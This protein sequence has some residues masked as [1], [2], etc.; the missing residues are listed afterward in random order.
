MGAQQSADA[1]AAV[2]EVE[3]EIAAEP[4]GC[5]IKLYKYVAAGSAGAWELVTNS[6]R[7]QFYDAKEDTSKKSD[8]YLEVDGS[9]VDVRV[10]QAAGFIMDPPH[11]RVTFNA[12]GSVWAM[13]VNDTML[14]K[15]FAVDLNNK[16]FQNTYGFENTEAGRTKGLGADYA[17]RMFSMEG[18]ETRVDEPMDV[19]G[20]VDQYETPDKLNERSHFEEDDDDPILGV[21]MGATDNSYLM[22]AGGRFDVLRNVV[23]GGVEDKA[24]SFMLTPG[25]HKGASTSSFTP[26]RVL[27]AQCERRMNL[28]T[29]HD[30]NLLHHADVE[31][32]KIVSTYNFQKDSVDIPIKEIAHDNKAAQ[33]DGTSTFLGLDANRLCRWDLRTAGGKVTDSSVVSYQ[34]GKDYSRGTNFN[35]MATSGDGFVVVGAQDGTIRLYSSS[36]LTR[37]KTSIPGMGAPVTSVDVTYDGKWVVATTD[38]YMMVVKTTYTNDKGAL[39]NGFVNPMGGRGSMPRLLRLKPE[40]RARTGGKP[41]AK[42]KF[43]WITESGTSERWIVASCGANSV[44]WNFNKVKSASNEVLSFGGLPTNMDYIIT[45]KEEDVV[46]AAFQHKRYAQDDDDASVVVATQH[47]VFNLGN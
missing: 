28:L 23:G 35:C 20:D 5:S 4:K 46:D 6:A 27:L 39:A 15:S 11:G 1:A 43:S 18:V 31:T 44:I 32:G 24:V 41:L 13:K 8:W 9:D 36:S 17:G 7:P 30:P 34:E 37:A 33:M 16:L 42:G 14:F 26:S 21:I 19:E 3:G 22:K 47:S 45:S 25:T 40:D 10:D 29:P 12:G 38:Q 2:D